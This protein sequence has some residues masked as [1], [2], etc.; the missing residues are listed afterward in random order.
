MSHFPSF[1]DLLLEE[2]ETKE[3]GSYHLKNLEGLAILTERWQS[4]HS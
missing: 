1:A 2:I 3:E 4:H